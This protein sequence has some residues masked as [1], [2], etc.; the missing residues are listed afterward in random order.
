MGQGTTRNE[1]E[2]LIADLNEAADKFGKLQEEEDQEDYRRSK[3]ERM[4]APTTENETVVVSKYLRNLKD[5]CFSVA[6]D[7]DVIAQYIRHQ[8]HPGV[9]PR[10]V[11]II[12]AEG[13]E[14]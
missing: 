5:I 2:K 12:D 4:F 3:V 10:T 11:S 9:S 8:R 13:L 6:V 14:K 7:N 1:L